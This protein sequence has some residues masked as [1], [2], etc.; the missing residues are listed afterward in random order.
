MKT[1]PANVKSAKEMIERL[2]EG[3][4]FILDDEYL[5]YRENYESPFRL[6]N[7]PLQ[8]FLCYEEL[9]T[10]IAWTEDLGRG[11]PCWVWDEGDGERSIELITS[12]SK[13][14]NYPYEGSISSWQH[15]EPIKP[16][17]CY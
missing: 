17:E 15:A 7:L 5:D 9:L 4:V 3:E 16:E 13:S 8:N 12:I 10:E 14:S 2:L 1:K 11:V 6:G